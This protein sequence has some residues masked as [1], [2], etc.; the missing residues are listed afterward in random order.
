VQTVP[1]KNSTSIMQLRNRALISLI[2]NTN[3]TATIDET[4][5]QRKN[6]GPPKSMCFMYLEIFKK[7]FPLIIQKISEIKK[8]GII[9][10]ESNVSMRFKY[11]IRTKRLLS[12][13]TLS[14]FSK[15]KKP[16]RI[17][18][19]GTPIFP[20]AR[21]KYLIAPVNGFKCKNTIRMLHINFNISKPS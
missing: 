10:K 3:K 12:S 9:Q 11:F 13:S 6:P 16:D 15:N 2:K 20:I 4:I 8:Y 7:I 5:Y 14:S 17:K 1:I 18:K 19:Q 21:E